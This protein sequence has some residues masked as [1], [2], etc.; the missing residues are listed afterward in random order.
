MTVALQAL[1]P[2]F[3]VIA[4]G[5]L[6]RRIG[7][8]PEA[9]WGPVNRFG[10]LLF[11][12]A[13]LFA[14]IAG[15]DFG[16]QGTLPFLGVLIASFGCAGAIQ[17]LLVRPLLG[18]D[19]P[20]FTSVFQAGARWHGF[21]L[22]AAAPALYGP[23]GPGLVALAF[24]PVVAF[25]NV[26]SVLVMAKWG[27][28]AVR[29]GVL[30]L[31]GEVVRNPLIIGCAAGIA[32]NLTGLAPH[33]GPV[34]EAARIVGAAAMP[35]ALLCV[36]AALRFEGIRR[37]PVHLAAG[38]GAKLLLLPAIAWGIAALAGLGPLETAVAVG[39]AATPTAAASYMLAQEMGGN[40]PLM[41]ALVSVTTVL[42]ALSM[43]VWLTLV[44][45]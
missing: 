32:V 26:M 30:G 6:V 5:W 25:V 18:G 35:V 21:I 11:Y 7:L 29:P 4:A 9:A 20:S 45:P 36:G 37:W 16:G 14:T 38:T 17:V 10:Y 27:A 34:T 13:F 42:A 44:A 33:L 12:P 22:I 24:G 43:P 39:I 19:G 2:V 28:G 3:A 8:V 40:A 1:V 23:A 31:V 41:A 15:A